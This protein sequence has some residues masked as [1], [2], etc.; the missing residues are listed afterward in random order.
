MTPDT[1][2]VVSKPRRKAYNR[3]FLASTYPYCC[4]RQANENVIENSAPPDEGLH[5]QCPKHVMSDNYNLVVN[6]KTRSQATDSHAWSVKSRVVRKN[7]T[8]RTQ[9]LSGGKLHDVEASALNLKTRRV[10]CN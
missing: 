7:D 1:L 9:Q 10:S 8:V 4:I 5:A 2:V 3:I 6:M